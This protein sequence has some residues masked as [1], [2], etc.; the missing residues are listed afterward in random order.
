MGCR[1]Y[2]ANFCAIG[3]MRLAGIWL[4]GNGWP[5]NRLRRGVAT[6]EKSPRRIAALVT[7]AVESVGCRSWFVAW[8]EKKKNGLFG[9]TAVRAQ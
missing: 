6:D 1:K 4:L 5:V 7:S 3:L 8:Y 2:C 9:R